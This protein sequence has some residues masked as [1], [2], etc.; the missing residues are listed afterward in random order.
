MTFR[1]YRSPRE[2]ATSQKMGP[3]RATH[4]STLEA[5]SAYLLS[6][7][8]RSSFEHHIQSVRYSITFRTLR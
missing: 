6:D 2:R 4:A 8:A 3:R 7:E 5:R 1:P